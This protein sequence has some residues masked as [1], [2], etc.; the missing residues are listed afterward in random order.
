MNYSTT[1]TESATACDSYTWAANGQTYT[2]SGTYTATSTNAAGCPHTS[3]LNLIVNYSTSSSEYATACDS[4]TW[5]A[6]GQTYTTSGTYTATSQNSAGCTHTTTLN[7]TVNYSTTSSESATACDSYTWGENGQTYTT[8]GTYTSTST[9]AA[10]CTHTATLNLTVNYSTSSSE[11]AFACDSYTWNANGQTYTTSGTYT[12]TSTNAAGC[13]HTTTLTLFVSYSTSSS[14]YATACDSYTWNENGQ[15]YTTSGTYTATSQNSAGCTH[16]TTLNLTINNSTTSTQSATACDSYTW[17]ENGQTY[18]TSGTYTATSTN[19]A[20]CTHTA[21]LNL[22]VNYS[23]TST[24]SATACDSYTWSADGNT[25]TVSGTYTATSTNASGCTHTSTLNLI[26]NYSTTASEYATACDS[27]TWNANGQTYT[28]SGSYTATSTNSA[29]CTRTTTLYLTINNSTTSTQSATACDS[30]TWSE[31]GQTYTTSGTYTAT[32]TNAAGCTHTATLNLTVNYSTTS[33][34][35]ATACDSYTWSANGQTYTTSGTY[36]ATSTNAAGCPHTSTLNLVVNYSTTASEYAT[37]CDSYTWNAN[38]QTYTTSGSYTATSTNSAGCTRTTTLYLTINNSTTSTQ[39]A[40]ACDSYTWSENG[41]T[42]TTSGTYT[43][44]STNAAGCTHTATLNLTVNYSTT[45]TQSAAACNSYTWSA[46]GQTYTTSGTYTA[47]STNASGCTHTSTLNLVINYSTTSTQNTTACDSYTWSANGQTYTTSGTYTATSTNT[48]GCTHTSTLNLTI[49]HSSTSTESATACD[50]YT[51]AANGQTYT[52][53]GTYTSTSTNASG[54]THTSTLQLSINHS[55]SSTQNVTICA[56]QSYTPPGGTPQNTSGTYVT[57]TT[58]S[59]GCTHT[60]TTNLTVLNPIVVTA[61]PGSIHC[62]GGT[63]TVTVSATGGTGTYTSGTGSIPNQGAGPHTYTVTDSQGCTGTTSITIT[64][65]NALTMGSCSHTDATCNGGTG[66]V[67]AGAVSNAVGPVSYVWKNASNVTVGTTATVSGLAAGTYTLT[68]TDDCFS[69][70]CSQTI[71]QP[72]A[73]SMSACSHTNA[74]YSGASNG[75]VSAGAVS[76][77]VGTPSYVWK[78]AS[79]V[80]VGTSA[81]VSGLPAGTYTLTVS[82]NCTSTTC[83]QTITQPAP[84]SMGACS[85]TDVSCNGGSNGSVSAGTLSNA[86]G[87]PSY[88]W[89]NSSNVTVGTTAT[90]SGLAP[91]TYTLTVTDPSGSVTCSQTISQPSAV[92][93]SATQGAAIACYGGTTC[94]TVTASGGTPPYYGTG[95]FCGVTAGTSSY[96]VSDS[97]GCMSTSSV[98]I[99]EPSKVEASAP[100]TTPASCANNDG[101]ATTSGSGGTPNYS[102]VWKNSSNATVGTSATATGLTA[103]TYTVTVTDANG[104]TGTNSAVVGS[105]GGGSSSAPGVIS[106]PSGACR[107][108]NGVQFCVDPVVGATSYSWTLPY[109]A[110]GSSTGNC[111]TVNFGTKYSGGQI[112]VRTNSACGASPY[113]CKTLVRFTAS[114]AKPGTIIA[115]AN[116]CANACNPYSVS[117]VT[118]ATGYYWSATSG[119]TL[120]SGQGTTNAVFCAS[121]TFTSGTVSVLAYNCYG[122]SSTRTITVIGNPGAPVW[123]NSGGDN[124]TVGVCAGSTGQYE[125]AALAGVNTF[126]WS[127]PAG[128][129]IN[130]RMGHTGNPL[131]VTGRDPIENE[132]E[133]DITFPS[134]FVSGNVTVY[135]VNSCGAGQPATLAVRST[136]IPPASISGPTSGVC[137]TSSNYYEIAASP[138]ATGYTWTVPANAQIVSGQ[139]T[140]KIK[141]KYLSGFTSGN[142]TVKANNAC[143]SSATTVLTVSGAPATPG[144]ISGSSTACKSYTN[145]TYS[146]SSV[147]NASSYTWTISG[148]AQITSGQGSNSIKVKFTTSTSSTVTLTVKAN[149]SCGSSSAVS[150]TIAVNLS[151]RTSEDSPIVNEQSLSA[152]PNPTSGKATVSF[153]ADRNAKYTMKVVDMIGNILVNESI[154]ATEGFNTNEINLENVAKGI[155]LISVQTEGEEAQTMRLIVE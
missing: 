126:V 78:N 148:G 66:S 101:T 76:N 41:Q 8:S 14:E 110:T 118:N 70:T 98:T 61:T 138:G 143:G 67:T 150:K 31:N 56:G 9:N 153:T 87:T 60:T 95:T 22:T 5:N 43:A 11:T 47:T 3:T 88:T 109:G 25:Y 75:S 135:G 131:T 152:Y 59:Q 69:R 29:G 151:C 71:A 115:A 120:Q 104:C 89:K 99:T 142:I 34:E 35:S 129:V 51:W 146:I 122:Y 117:P 55:T 57:T 65:P 15:T 30:Y 77:A 68:V 127:A 106:G 20:G 94:V 21:T 121:S 93:S 108:Q 154:S 134:G 85:H 80:T 18:T 116:H 33:T 124:L 144:A 50:S 54:C 39:S 44:T 32:S 16:T 102:Y 149:N 139:N 58:N 52:S 145:K 13:T 53:S 84:M 27:Y 114:P 123:Y 90:V 38:G 105:S 72:T 19:A 36:T 113:T 23:T 137:N 73:M 64:Q 125:V 74:T 155:Y 141:V 86:S 48:A 112:C 62:N 26:V 82:D 42:Y 140:T 83:S 100:T 28:T 7:L 130:D 136:P 147:S 4:Y 107:G 46:N 133:V 10:G 91:G 12:A 45:S 2:T 96:E 81:T 119:L 103:G 24:E 111:I 37:A 79:N 63:T 97:K 17:S 49:N 1:S 132:Y 128:A 6:N 92:T 40:T